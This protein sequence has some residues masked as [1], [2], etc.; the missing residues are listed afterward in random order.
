MSAKVTLVNP[1]GKLENALKN[2]GDY[3]TGKV[4]RNTN[5]AYSKIPLLFR[6]TKLRCNML[7]RVPVYVYE[8]KKIVEKYAFEDQLSLR[9]WLWKS[10]ASML[11][12]GNGYILKN[13]NEFGYSKGVQWLNPFT[14]FSRWDNG[15]LK[16]WQEV[17]GQQYPESGYWTL[18]D[19]IWY[20]EFNPSSDYI[21]LAAAQVALTGAQISGNVTQ[22]L[23]DFFGSDAIPITMV[24][25]PAGTEKDEIDKLENW[26]S[27]KL[28]Q[29]KAAAQ[30]VLGLRGEVKIE[31]LTN[32]L[33]SYDFDKIDTSSVNAVSDAF[34]VPQSLLRSGS[35]ANRAI[36]DNERES[37]INDTIIPRCKYHETMINPFLEEFGQR[38]EFAPEEMPELQEDEVQRSTAL[39]DLI[40]AGIPLDA[41]LD[42]LG[43]DLSD[44]AKS[45]IDKAIQLKEDSRKRMEDLQ[46]KTPANGGNGN[47]LSSNKPDLQPIKTELD[48][49]LRKSLSKLKLDGSAKT[50]FESDL[51]PMEIKIGIENLLTTAQEETQVRGIFREAIQHYEGNGNGR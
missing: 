45:S 30:R 15:V 42:I 9:D 14:V 34:E 3:S 47:G 35:G 38:I 5:Q 8:G 44:E 4:A 43:Y 36:S 18:E 39:N 16:I 6:A 12:K 50:E 33:K 49:W 22:F 10:E 28:S 7:T 25:A 46:S 48:K 51:I 32:E 11:L 23:A 27:K 2:L 40:G 31:T 17:D 20:Y 21:G 29:A 37:F 41:A 26:F 19:F 1:W 13:M 24:I